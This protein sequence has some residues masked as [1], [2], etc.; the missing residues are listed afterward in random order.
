MKSIQT[1]LLISSLRSRKDGSLGLSANTPELTSEEKVALMDLQLVPLEV[2]LK[3]I[4]E[5][6]DEIIKVDKDV[7]QKT[8]A[9]K[10]RSVLWL[11]W[12]QE[13]EPGEFNDYYRKKT[14]KIIDYLKDKLD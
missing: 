14:E 11:L 5:P 1:Q 13:G 2:L 10:L 3:P 6:T 12:R 9:Q 8:Q 7:G 4:D